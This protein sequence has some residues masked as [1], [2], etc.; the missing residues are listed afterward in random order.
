MFFPFSQSE[1]EKFPAAPQESVVI[2]E[3]GSAHPS[4]GAENPYEI[5]F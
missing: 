1:V 5:S 2:T 3:T 4:Q